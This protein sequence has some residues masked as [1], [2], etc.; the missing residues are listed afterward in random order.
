MRILDRFEDGAL[1]AALAARI[2]VLAR[3]RGAYAFM[4][5]CGTH[6]HAIGR[7]GIRR[8][9]PDNVRLVS[10]PGCPV[11]VTPGE[12]IDNAC[13]LALERGVVLATFGDLMRVPGEETTLE[14]ARSRGAQVRT[15]YSPFDAISLAREA[16]RDVVFLAVGFETTIA[17]IAATVRAAHEE[18]IPNLSFYLSLRLIPPVLEALLADPQVR[19]DGFLLPGHVSVIIGTG[20]YCVLRRHGKPGA[21][22]GFEPVDILHGVETL[23]ADVNAGVAE[24][25]NLYPQVVRDE[26][27]THARRLFVELFDRTDAVWRGLG[28]VPGS[29]YELRDQ[30]ASLDAAR[31]YSLGPMSARVSAGCVCGDVLKGVKLPPE[32]PFFGKGCT[33]AHPVGPCMV[34]SEGS[35][36]AHYKYRAAE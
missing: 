4:E 14:E 29:G 2:G 34:A 21:I 5:V 31:R 13:R 22:V 8:I 18:R 28:A 26:G 19:L 12:Y 11:C 3:E 24:V 23:L 32:C 33:P 36:S 30:Y 27:N 35:C 7:W 1:V 9:V 20:P 25:R 6:T 17:A 10:G 15:V 16:G